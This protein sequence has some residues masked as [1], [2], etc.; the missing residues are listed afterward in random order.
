M[1]ESLV[2]FPGFGSGGVVERA[3]ALGCNDFSLTACPRADGRIASA[4]VHEGMRA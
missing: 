3:G 4:C 2:G 1:A